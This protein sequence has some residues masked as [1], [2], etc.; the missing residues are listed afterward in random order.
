MRT[1]KKTYIARDTATHR[2]PPMGKR[3]VDRSTA[4]TGRGY[5][6]KRT[7]T[8]GMIPAVDV[9][10]SRCSTHIRGSHVPDSAR[11]V[12]SAFYRP[13]IRLRVEGASAMP[14]RFV[15]ERRL[16]KPCPESRAQFCT[17]K[18]SILGESV[19]ERPSVK[20]NSYSLKTLSGVGVT[21]RVRKSHPEVTAKMRCG[22]NIGELLKSQWPTANTSVSSRVLRKLVM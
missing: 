13:Q 2:A 1:L 20:H 10:N 3:I 18:A 19:G 9:W 16:R 5:A 17:L 21:R 6:G 11:L 14:T 22:N 4:S 15:E 7:C 8:P 12:F